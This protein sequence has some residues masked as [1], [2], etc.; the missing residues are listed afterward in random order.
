MKEYRIKYGIGLD[1]LKALLAKKSAPIKKK[2]SR[3]NI[4][5]K[6]KNNHVD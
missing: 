4:K 5:V 3:N 1:L 6:I 2:E